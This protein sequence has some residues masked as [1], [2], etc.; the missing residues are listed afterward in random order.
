[1]RTLLA[2]PLLLAAAAAPAQGYKAVKRWVAG[3]DNTRHCSAIGFAPEHAEGMAMLHFERGAGADD[4]VQRIT[5]RVD[6]PVSREN[7]WV[8]QVDDAELLQF[9][10]THLVD[11]DSGEGIDIAITDADEIAAMFGA[12]RGADTLTLVGDGGPVGTFSL[13][14]ASA[15]LLWIDE[16][17]QRLGTTTAFVRKGDKPATGIPAPPPLRQV[18]AIP[19]GKPLEAV[20]AARLGKLVRE[21][22]EADM[23]ESAADDERLTDAAWELPDGRTLVQ[24]TCYAGAYNYG[25]SWFWL[26]QGAQPQMI[27]FPV[28]AEDGSGKMTVTGDLVNA[29]F[30]PATG[31]LDMF[32]KG[33]GI[34]DCGARGIWVFDGQHFA[35]VEYALM[36]DCQGVTPDFWPVL[37]RSAR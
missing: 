36:S 32:S 18:N 8:L 21:T 10:D 22:L 33:R 20:E 1:M 2:L 7:Y 35:L 37:W 34:G 19:G 26:E 24:L 31:L 13:S 6:H 23:C 15:I 28:P 16:Q 30:D 14:G 3:C 4:A 25:S 9:N 11:A 29:S 17:Q 27:P 5:L 12:M